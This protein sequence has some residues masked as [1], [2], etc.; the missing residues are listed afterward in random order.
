[1]VHSFSFSIQKIIIGE[2][3][4][5]EQQNEQ[6]LFCHFLCHYYINCINSR[7]KFSESPHRVELASCAVVNKTPVIRMLFAVVVRQRWQPLDIFTLAG[8]DYAGKRILEKQT[9]HIKPN[10]L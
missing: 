6:Y 9:P 1:M 10:S 2:R 3:K 4:T 5:G 7:S 8:V